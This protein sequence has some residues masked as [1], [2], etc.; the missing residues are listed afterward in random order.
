MPPFHSGGDMIRE[1]KLDTADFREAPYRFEAGTPNV[2]GVLGLKTA[3]DY[4]DGIGFEAILE[5][6]KKLM[7]HALLRA[8]EIQRLKVYGPL[9]SDIQGSVFSFNIGSIHPHD[10]GTVLNEHGI[11]VR[12]GYHCAQPYVEA[13]GCGGTV[14]ASMAFYNTREEI[15]RL[16]E[17][18]RAA[19]EIFGDFM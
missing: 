17:G 15:D 6:E 9:N 14:R 8:E 4:L 3:L 13:M 7:N 11:A 2:A 1:V 19:E 12:A 10:V 5:A 18:I 16:F